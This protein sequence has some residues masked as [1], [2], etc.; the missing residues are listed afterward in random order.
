VRCSTVLVGQDKRRR[1]FRH[2]PLRRG[3]RQVHLS[4]HFALRNQG[5]DSE[6]QADAER[7]AADERRASDGPRP[8][9]PLGGHVLE[10]VLDS[11]DVPTRQARQIGF[12]ANEAD[13][14]DHKRCQTQ[15]L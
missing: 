12:E 14:T 9:Q 1:T 15:S 3:I 13:E 11:F 6:D 4:Q 10:L 5:N 8:V 2:W 7:D